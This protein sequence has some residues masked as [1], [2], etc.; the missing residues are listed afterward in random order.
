MGNWDNEPNVEESDDNND[1]DLNDMNQGEEDATIRRKITT[2]I[3]EEIVQIILI[4]AYLAL[5]TE[6]D[7]TDHTGWGHTYAL[8][9]Q[10]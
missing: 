10:Q 7:L 6:Q 5:I 8:H 4:T 2:W 3:L 9:C 1:C